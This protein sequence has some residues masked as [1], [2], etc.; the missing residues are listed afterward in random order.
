MAAE[1]HIV[2]HVQGRTVTFGEH[3]IR[4]YYE[5]VKP[6][7][8]DAAAAAVDLE[9]TV[10][11]CGQI[12]TVTPTWKDEVHTVTKR[13]RPAIAWLM[14]GDDIAFPLTACL[15]NASAFFVP[16][17]LSRG[18]CGDELRARRA[19]RRQ[20]ESRARAHQRALKR[21]AKTSRK[22]T[23]S[24]RAPRLRRIVDD[25]DLEEAA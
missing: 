3:S 22:Q 1:L 17:C 21:G 5:R 7:L 10:R 8:P 13:E 14:I 18:G 11:A 16:T 9:R 19:A 15:R 4:R 6:M 25:I 12:V 2:T 23:A 20:S 24:H